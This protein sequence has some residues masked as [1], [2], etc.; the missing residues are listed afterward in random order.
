MK[1]RF[2]LRGSLLRPPKPASTLILFCGIALVLI[3]FT[4]CSSQPK[5]TPTQPSSSTPSNIPTELPTTTIFTSIAKSVPVSASSTPF[6][7]DENWQSLP[8]IPTVT[9][10]ARKLFQQGIAEG[11][12]PHAF[13]KIG[14]GEISTEWFLTDFDLGHYKLGDYQNL[15]AVIENF[16]GSFSRIGIAAHRGFNTN[17]ILDPSASDQA[18]CDSNESP[19][20]CEMRIH[21]PSIVILSLGT[22]QVHRP[23][24]FE[25]GM[26]Q[27]LQ[28]LLSKSVLPIL[29]TKGD[30]LEGDYRINRTIACL[31]QEYQIPRWN[32]WAA[33]QLLPHQGLQPDLE[34]LT[35]YG[36]NDFAN[37]HAMQS[38]WTVRNLT[39]LQVLDTVWQ[40]V[41]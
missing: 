32:F 27:I 35:Y 16:Q 38:A 31:A 18:L 12:D 34:H 22:N 21:K 36:S 28:I 37:P 24:E 19:L 25:L 8:I 4:S 14:D 30:N 20:E 40:E 26:R 41:K 10:T 29:S 6:I 13:S 9:D 33:I 3:L 2:A 1:I 7:C 11:N 39:A 23:E 17:L 5:S 15:Q